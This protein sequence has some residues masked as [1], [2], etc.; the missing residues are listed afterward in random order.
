MLKI[1]FGLNWL[2]LRLLCEYWESFWLIVASFVNKGTLA[3]KSSQFGDF[4]GPLWWHLLTFLIFRVFSMLNFFVPLASQGIFWH[5]SSW[6]FSQ[7][8]KGFCF[9]NSK[10]LINLYSLVN[11]GLISQTTHVKRRSE[12]L[13]KK[14]ANFIIDP[15]TWNVCEIN[16]KPSTIKSLHCFWKTVVKF[17]QNHW[18]SEFLDDDSFSFLTLSDGFLTVSHLVSLSCISSNFFTLL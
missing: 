6:L 5:T 15:H 18:K 10:K 8:F 12:F 2:S 16:A 17:T 7:I 13:T 9:S 4:F 14:H 3:A 11:F 1:V